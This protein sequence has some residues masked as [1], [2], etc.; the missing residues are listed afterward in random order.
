MK[1][2]EMTLPGVILIEPD[3]FVDDRGYFLETYRDARYAEAGV[4]GPFVQDNLSYSK[5]RILARAPLPE[6]A[7][8]GETRLRGR[9]RDLRR[10]R[11]RAPWLTHLRPLDGGVA[12]VR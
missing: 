3:V 6:P 11:G 1:P 10:R 4:A 5:A 7:R 2:S 8:P 9:R 12:F